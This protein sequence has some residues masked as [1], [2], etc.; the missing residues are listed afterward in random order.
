MVQ[1]SRKENEQQ[2][3]Q[4]KTSQ[5]ERS[6]ETSIQPLHDS[7]ETWKTFEHMPFNVFPEN[8]DTNLNE[9]MGDLT[10]IEQFLTNVP[11]ELLGM[12]LHEEK[13]NKIISLMI[14][15][16]KNVNELNRILIADANGLTPLNV[17]I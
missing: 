3:Q 13:Y 1:E 6:E 16:V 5:P 12:N 4:A 7:A 8:S 11:L 9:S 10:Q 2:S 17:R 14:K 15:M